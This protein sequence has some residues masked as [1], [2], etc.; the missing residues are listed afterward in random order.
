M[1]AIIPY[2]VTLGMNDYFSKNLWTIMH[3]QGS[4]PSNAPESSVAR[5]GNLRDTG[6]APVPQTPV[7]DMPFKDH[8]LKQLRAQCLVFLA[9][10]YYLVF[11]YL[12]LHLK[13]SFKLILTTVSV[14]F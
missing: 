13:A 2:F 11:G 4:F 9:F 14:V 8:H 5:P 10:R 1:A 12:L 7:S 3:I 6:K